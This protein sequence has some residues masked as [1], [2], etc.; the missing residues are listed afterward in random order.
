[1]TTA[2]LAA[3]ERR[4]AARALLSMPILTAH[5]HPDEFTLVRRHASALKSTFAT[6]LGYTL[7][8]ESRFARLVKA[9]LAPHAPVR[10]VRRPSGSEFS[11]RTYTHLALVCAG[12]LAPDVGAQILMSQ[13]VEQV[14]A[15]AVTAGITLDDTL[16]ERR[17]LVAAIEFL[18]DAGVIIETDGTVVG[19]GERKDE[20][21]IT[22]T[23]GLLPYLVTKPLHALESP[24]QL[25]ATVPEDPEQPR[26][27]L[28][29]KLVE[30]PLIHRVDL[31]DAER[32]VLS[33]ERTELTR[34]LD[35][36]FGLSLEVRAEGALVYDPDES[37]SDLE[38][39]G[40]GSVRQAAL[41]LTDALITRISP[42]A[43]T[44]VDLEGRRV[45]GVPAPWPLV[46]EA[47]RAL[48]KEHAKAWRT[49]AQDDL[50]RLRADVVAV[51]EAMGL[52]TE[53]PAGLVLHPAAARYR[54][55]VRLAS[56]VTRARRRLDEPQ[57]AATEPLFPL[58]EEPT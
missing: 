10:P 57:A 3:E 14:R 4:T 45:P 15:D 38:F 12:L 5:R 23:R 2:A 36:A 19:W 16:A 49:D 17:S 7:V 22:V 56:P 54:P 25:W 13:L 28:R 47:L 6:L 29:R 32:D 58:D 34:M 35:E 31:S 11:P 20:A 44:H 8:V 9:P 1:M 39:P 41:L 50:P 26:R 51:L 48:T 18:I 37:L 43:G 46:D 53:T 42:K 24:E 27:T 40:S 21:L 52:G 55:Q 33:R 30:N